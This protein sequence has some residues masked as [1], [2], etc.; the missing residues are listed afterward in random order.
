MWL[1]LVELPANRT[2]FVVLKRR[3]GGDSGP[4]LVLAISIVRF[5]NQFYAMQLQVFFGTAL[6]TAS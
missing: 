6:L 5:F 2:H 4:F 1:L 3:A